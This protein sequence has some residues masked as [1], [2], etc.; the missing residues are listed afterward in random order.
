MTDLDRDK[1]SASDAEDDDSAEYEVEPPDPE[2]LA[3]E[4][5]RAEEVIAESR[6]AIDIDAIYRDLED[7]RGE[8]FLGEWTRDFRFRFRVKHLL[9]ATAVLS[10]A[11]TLFKLGVLKHAL[12]LLILVTIAGVYLVVEW[13][14]KRRRNEA[15]R[16]REEIY[17]RVKGT[18]PANPPQPTSAPPVPD[19]TDPSDVRAAEH[20]QFRPR[21]SLRQ[22]LIAMT[23]AAAILGFVSFMGGPHEAAMMLGVIALAGLVIQAVGYDPPEIVVLGW[24][25]LLVL[26]IFLSIVASV[27]SGT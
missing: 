6:Q 7:H 14:E 8:D 4:R 27:W 12:L 2:V 18:R 21:F 26:Y 11:L 16:R 20:G 19:E 13:Q 1:F 25:L 5:R 23:I 3:N 15:D 9:I 17:A 10:V 22:L 24:W